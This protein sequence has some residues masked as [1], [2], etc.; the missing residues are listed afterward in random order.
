MKKSVISIIVAV[1]VIALVVVGIVVLNNN[2][3][4]NNESK[5]STFEDME[6]LVNDIHTKAGNEIMALATNEVDLTDEFAVEAY[7]GLKDSGNI[8]KLVV[9]EPMI[10]SIAYQM[11]IVKVKKGA[12]V[13]AIK[14]EMVD[15]V[16]MNRWF[17]VSA[18]VVYA[19]NNGDVIFLVM[20][21]K[22]QAKKEYDAFKEIVNNKIGKELE[23]EAEEIDF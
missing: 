12:D 20:T 2:K 22:E 17:C 1:L 4:E 10:S 16:D 15:N 14:K 3:G 8:D 23:R 6:K 21:K 7:T 19:T 13:E 5:F 9:S 11:A 18:D